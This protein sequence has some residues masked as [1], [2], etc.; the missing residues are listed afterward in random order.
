MSI[1]HIKRIYNSRIGEVM[2]IGNNTTFI[3]NEHKFMGS[4]HVMNSRSQTRTSS[5][6]YLHI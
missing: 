3:D 2:L 6:C 1:D 5:P 4:L